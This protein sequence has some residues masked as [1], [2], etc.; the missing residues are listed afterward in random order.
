MP[1]GCYSERGPAVLFHRRESLHRDKLACEVD[2]VWPGWG[3]AS[4]NPALPRTLAAN[5]VAFL[6]PTAP[7]MSALA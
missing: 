1:E 2:A 6:G 4:E 5:G 3:H 7:V